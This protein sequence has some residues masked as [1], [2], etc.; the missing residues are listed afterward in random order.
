MSEPVLPS[1]TEA[2]VQPLCQRRPARPR[3]PGSVCLLCFAYDFGFCLA[4]S[5]TLFT[6]IFYKEIESDHLIEQKGF[7]Y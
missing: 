1:D 6:C 5:L 3:P 4:V 7:I 2:G